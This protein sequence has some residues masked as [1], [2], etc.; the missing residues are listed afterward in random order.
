[1]HGRSV[2]GTKT[3]VDN[4]VI[5]SYKNKGLGVGFFFA[6]KAEGGQPSI[7]RGVKVTRKNIK[8]HQ[9]ALPHTTHYH[10]STNR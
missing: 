5:E 10:P 4:S 3:L 1:L 7:L 8:M 2:I 6:G 9:G